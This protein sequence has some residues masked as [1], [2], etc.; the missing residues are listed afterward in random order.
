ML[1]TLDAHETGSFNCLGSLLLVV[2]HGA[3]RGRLVAHLDRFGLFK[4]IVLVDVHEAFLLS[5]AVLRD[6]LGVQQTGTVL[7][8]A[9]LELLREVVDDADL[10]FE[11]G[12]QLVTSLVGILKTAVD[13][14]DLTFCLHLPLEQ[15]L[16][17]LCNALR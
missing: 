7:I 12:A 5:H 10:T 13:L 8:V 4:Y 16:L 15:V 17:A 11:V 2:V 9:M 14:L 3:G 6:R 1:V